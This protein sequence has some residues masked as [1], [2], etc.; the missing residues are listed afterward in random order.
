MTQIQFFRDRFESDGLGLLLFPI[1]VG[2]V[3]PYLLVGLLGARGVVRSLT[4]GAFPTLF[5]ST[6]GAVPPWLSGPGGLLGRADLH[7]FWRPA[8]R[9]LGQYVPDLRLHGHRHRRFR[10]DRL[11]AGRLVG[12]HRSTC[13]PMQPERLTRG[14]A[15]VAAGFFHLLADPAFGRHVPARVP[16]L[17]DGALGEEPFA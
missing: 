6:A 16:A 4:V 13:S 9:G 3:I 8:R 12:G 17:A 2:L 5:A 7:L 1:L 10:R 15:I 14:A 11:Q